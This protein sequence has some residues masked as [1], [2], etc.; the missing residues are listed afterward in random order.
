[1]TR[2]SAAVGRLRFPLAA[3]T[4]PS[5]VPRPA[6][7]RRV[8][9]DYDHEWSR[10]YP[11]RLVRAMVLDNVA[12]PIARIVAPTTIR[13]GER[14]A[15]LEPPV[16]LAANHTSHID[17][18][19]L[20]TTLPVRLR[21]RTVV[22]AASDYFFDRTWK[23]GLWALSLAAI[24]IE[25]SRINRRSTQTALDL[26]H[27]GWNLV[28]F[29]EGGRSPDGW[30]Q[31]FHPA[32]AAYLAVRSGRPVVP[33]HLHGT[34]AVLAKRPDSTSPPPGGSGAESAM[35]GRLHRAP[36][37]VTFGSAL[38]PQEGEDARRFGARIQEAVTVLGVEA[39][40]DFWRARRQLAQGAL[41]DPGGPDIAAWR[42][43]WAL[44]PPAR[45]GAERHEGPRGP[46]PATSPPGARRQNRRWPKTSN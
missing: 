46:A 23:S 25:R 3:P 20:L 21:H 29:P 26:L 28:I 5:G 22:G 35:T 40:Q 31:P 7:E 38:V 2:L 17:T 11:A 33:V 27:Q 13:G 10:R 41:P 4:W 36:V 37:A 19:L 15:H 44:G 8:G 32:A 34:R 12:R 1:M 14:L 30:T 24:P 43:A 45:Q 9:L 39:R 18:P 6:P 42:R 16:I